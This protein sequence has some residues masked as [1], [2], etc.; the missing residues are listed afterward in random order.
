MTEI[1]S[2]TGVVPLNFEK[3]QDMG[4]R[5]VVVLGQ[6]RGGTSLAAG[7][8]QHLGLPM[9]KECHHPIYEDQ[10]LTRAIREGNK[11]K[12]KELIAEY[13][14][15]WP[16]WGYKQPAVQNFWLR[17]HGLLRAPCYLLIIKDPISVGD[18][19]NQYRGHDTVTAARAAMKA[20]DKLLSFVSKTGKPALL[21]SYDKLYRYPKQCL[22]VLAELAGIAD[23]DV[24]KA[25]R[26][27]EAGGDDY[28][29]FFNRQQQRTSTGVDG[30]V[31]R[32]TEV[33][34]S[35]W[36]AMAGK[37]EPLEVEISINDHVVA[38]VVAD[39]ARPDLLEKNLHP[40]GHCGFRLNWPKGIKPSTGDRVHVTTSGQNSSGQNTSDQKI[41]LSRSPWLVELP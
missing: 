28:Q 24:D 41:H 12:V 40:T 23:P 36:A 11:S 10:P 18:R 19:L 9:G 20:Y 37:A 5:T 1:D 21:V 7:A 6:A 26:F 15:R 32:V 31:D 29:A 35:G 38:T 2:I 14:E 39:R 22:P 33:F 4:E 25:L 8:L 13:N 27:C 16:Q 3:L 30:H 34:V 17:N